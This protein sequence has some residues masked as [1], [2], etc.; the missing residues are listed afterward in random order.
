[1]N[2]KELEVLYRVTKTVNSILDYPQLME[3]VMDLAI[4]TVGAERGAIILLNP[5][6]NLDL[7]VARN[8]ERK[9]LKALTTLSSSVVRKVV[10]EKTPLLSHDLQDDACL[11]DSKSILS[12]NIQSVLCVPLESKGQISGVIYVDSR[13]TK[14]VFTKDSLEFLAAFSDQAAIALENARLHKLVSD[15]NQRLKQEL[16]H[17]YPFESIVGKS[18]QMQSVFDV[19]KRLVKSSIPVM[20]HGETGTGKE[21]VARALHYNSDRKSARFMPIYCGS[22]PDSLLESELFGYKK[23]AFTGAL[24]DKKGLFEEAD[25]GTLFL[26]E[27]ADVSLATQAKLLRVLEEQEFFRIGDTTPR[28]VDVRVVSATNKDIA[29]EIREKRFREDL[30]Y[31][32]NVVRIELPA[33]RERT[34]DIPILAGHFLAKYS[35]KTDKKVLRF[36][37]QAMGML[38]RHTWPGNVRELENLIAR[39]VTMATSSEITVDDLG[40][41]N[42][43]YNNN[44][45]P[46]SSLKEATG[47]FEVRYV[48]RVLKECNGNRKLAASRLGISLRSLQYKIQDSIR[49]KEI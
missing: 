29:A 31:R 48:K 24:A 9:N 27:I 7:A 2:R 49:E 35:A 30:Y 18:P 42:D 11:K 47:E 19:M 15:E 25:K 38:E 1:M 21:L 32:L 43:V 4:E 28:S 8:F 16:S 10:N 39:G 34:G 41:E 44:Q 3:K 26:D 40:L 12:H 6:G 46:L 23:G 13:S 22:L 36:T 45:L 5:Y 33:L 17:D 14:G 37:S 20:I